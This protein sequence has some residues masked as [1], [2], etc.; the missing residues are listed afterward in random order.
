MPDQPEW[1][2]AAFRRQ[3]RCRDWKSLRTR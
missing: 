3:A 1:E 2:A